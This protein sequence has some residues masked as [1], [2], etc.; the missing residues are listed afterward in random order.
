MMKIRPFHIALLSLLLAAV[1][2]TLAWGASPEAAPSTPAPVSVEASP[3]DANLPVAVV[4]V[5]QIG[6]EAGGAGA[7]SLA[8]RSGEPK[9]D[10]QSVRMEDHLCCQVSGGCDCVY[11]PGAECELF[12]CRGGSC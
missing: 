5:F 3:A 8:A 10:P 2:V 12:S 7:A 4:P 6:A 11:W 1:P 9:E